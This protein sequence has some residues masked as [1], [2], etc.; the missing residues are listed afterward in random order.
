[1]FLADQ[2]LVYMAMSDQ[3]SE[4]ISPRL[5]KHIQTNIEVIKQFINTDF[6]IENGTVRIRCTRKQ[7]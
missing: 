4:V 2:L 1:M 7:S 3:S 6:Y 5:T